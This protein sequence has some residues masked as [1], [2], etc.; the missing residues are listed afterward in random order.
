VNLTDVSD[1]TAAGWADRVRDRVDEHYFR[2]RY[3]FPAA[4]AVIDLIKKFEVHLR[5]GDL[6]SIIRNKVRSS[7]PSFRAHKKDNDR[8]KVRYH[9]QKD[10]VVE[11]FIKGLDDSVINREMSLK[12]INERL[13]GVLASRN[14][15]KA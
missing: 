15:G 7:S 4:A 6:M 3:V 14:G 10:I 8:P 2:R 12:M 11:E 5:R 9:K 13:R 1:G